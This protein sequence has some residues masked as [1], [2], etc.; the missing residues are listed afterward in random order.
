V[1]EQ[2]GF[3]LRQI[4][5]RSIVRL[6][7]RSRG[8]DAA[9]KALQLPQEAFHSQHGDPMA[10]WIGPDQWLLTSENK[11]VAEILE[12]IEG[13]LA[14]QLYAATNMSSG[15]TCFAIS[16]SAARTALAMG[17]GV[18]MHETAF[19]TGSCVRT[20]FSQVPLFIVATGNFEFDLYVDRSYANY[21]QDW[22]TAAGKDPITHAS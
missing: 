16:G 14:G 5:G 15:Y 6:R 1:P 17:C 10:Y 4:D 7:V 19:T 22:L 12:H 21:L 8:A 3:D 18:D 9:E 20:R 13:A 2:P 11:P